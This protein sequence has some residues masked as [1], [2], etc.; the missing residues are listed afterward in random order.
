MISYSSA[1]E[2]LHKLG[3]ELPQLPARKFDLEHVRVLC[4]ALADPQ[5]DFPCVLIAGTNGKG[6]TAATLASILRVSSLR[7]GLYTSPHL[8]RVNER[9]RLDGQPIDDESFA[10]VYDRVSS[11]ASRLVANSELPH[12]PSFF[13]TVTAMAF[14]YFSASKVDIAVLEVGMGGRLDATN[15][16]E[17]ILSVIT[18]IDL[19]HQKYLG[20]T[21]AEIAVEKAGILRKD[22]A[23]VTLP[24]HPEANR[25]LGER[26][27][28][29]GARAVNAAR[30]MASVATG[31]SALVH[32]SPTETRFA[33]S[34][35]GTEVEIRSPLVG[36]HQIRN[37]ALAITAAEELAPRFSGITA[38]SIARGVAE[39]SWPGRFQRLA[40]NPRRP[41]II[42]DVAHNPAGA[43]ALRSALSEL[44]GERPL[45]L[46]F[47]AMSDKA[48]EQMAEI[49]WPQMNHVVLTHVSGNPRAAT[50]EALNSIAQKLGVEYS[51]SDT[52]S[53]GLKIALEQA[54]RLG[55]QTA[56][57]IAGSIYL[58]GEAMPLLS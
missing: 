14:E 39:T 30:N 22:V 20:S 35:L 31:A 41:E 16:V 33:L 36:R 10:A 23:A 37:L 51:V 26:M 21:I 38:A 24:Q 17:P 19:D 27:V 50:L 43:W 52:V 42:L 28:A 6:S 13:E 49:L 29:L 46:L 15:I 34:V 3:H 44:A 4:R 40:A 56:V 58:A 7:V 12:L 9:I 45:V 25:V 11:T 8:L 55:P 48:V 5:C 2:C 18:D 53:Q 57:V 54:S 32:A 47:A 1:V